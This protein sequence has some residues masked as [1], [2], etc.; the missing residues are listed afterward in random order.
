[1]VLAS[2]SVP[3]TIPGFEIDG[4]LVSTSDEVLSLERLPA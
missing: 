2:G 3:R 4:E 1:M